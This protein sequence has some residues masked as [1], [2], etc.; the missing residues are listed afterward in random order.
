L[1]PLRY[2]DFTEQP[3][4]LRAA[5]DALAAARNV[6]ALFVPGAGGCGN[7]DGS[8]VP[9]CHDSVSEST[10][11]L[12]SIF[13]DIYDKVAQEIERHF[14]PIQNIFIVDCDC[15][16]FVNLTSDLKCFYSCPKT[17]C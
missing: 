4:L 12:D 3:A 7:D 5:Q 10:F 8:S 14:H 2:Q 11:P 6:D 15:F 9:T 13:E 16:L 17:K 1:Q